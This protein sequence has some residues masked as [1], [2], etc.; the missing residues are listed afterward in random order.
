MLFHVIVRQ[1]VTFAII[2]TII[3]HGIILVVSSLVWSAA[4]KITGTLPIAISRQQIRMN[5]VYAPLVGHY[6]DS[7]VI[8]LA[9]LQYYA[10]TIGHYCYWLVYAAMS[11]RCRHNNCRHCY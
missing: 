4:G 2:V 7:M 1:R 6:A 9:S 3:R 11:I 5:N 8:V 10:I